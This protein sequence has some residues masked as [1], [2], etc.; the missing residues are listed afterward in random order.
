[1]TANYLPPLAAPSPSWPWPC[2]TGAT[3]GGPVTGYLREPQ[4][5]NI[6]IK[7]C[8]QQ[9]TEPPKASTA[10]TSGLLAWRLEDLRGVP[11]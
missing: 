8:D 6:D 3:S 10:T 9:L 11:S 4:V 1:M 2:T 7:G 5:A